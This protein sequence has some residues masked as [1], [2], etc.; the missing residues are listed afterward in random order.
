MGQRFFRCKT[1]IA[2]LNYF[3]LKSTNIQK[4]KTIEFPENVGLKLDYRFVA[5]QLHFYNPDLDRG[6]RDTG[7]GI[8][9]SFT[10]TL[11]EN[12]LGIIQVY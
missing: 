2:F 3:Y 12:N 4:S 9:L 1:D 10:R 8:Y 6:I 5:L 11:R 7:T